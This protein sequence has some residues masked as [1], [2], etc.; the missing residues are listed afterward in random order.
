MRPCNR[1]PIVRSAARACGTSGRRRPG[2]SE[3][4]DSIARVTFTTIRLT[5]AAG[6]CVHVALPHGHETQIS[7]FATEAAAKAWIAEKSAAW[8]K[9]Y[10]G[11][12]YA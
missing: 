5:L 4:T 6:W 9:D 8:L 10:D 11:G 12:K 3:M 2:E 7:G 1:Y